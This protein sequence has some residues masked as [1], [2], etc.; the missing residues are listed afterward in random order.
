[1]TTKQ[2]ANSQK[3]DFTQYNT[4]IWDWNGTLL[5]DVDECIETMNGLLKKRHIPLLDKASYKNI[6]GFPV[7][8]YYEKLGFDFSTESWEDVAAEYMSGY[9]QREDSFSLYD[10]VTSTLKYFQEKGYK[11]YI[12]SAMMQNSLVQMLSDY[13]IDNF[14]DGIYG[15]DN[16]YA[17][18]KI[19][20]GKLFINNEKIHPENCL[21]IG[22]TIHDAEV[23]K[24]L[25][26]DCILI[27]NGHQNS[28]RLKQTGFEVVSCLS[29]LLNKF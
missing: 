4:I 18:E 17:E 19:A 8:D 1:M 26:T 20:L 6:F 11:Q 24:A 23:A 9:H 2:N 29:E 15:L 3:T 27:S 5:N 10:D 16:H 28:E 13:A 21:L 12:L 25:N 22:D 7:I 14:F